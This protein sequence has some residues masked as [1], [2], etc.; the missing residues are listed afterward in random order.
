M[1]GGETLDV[2]LAKSNWLLCEEASVGREAAAREENG[3]AAQGDTPHTTNYSSD[4]T[5]RVLVVC[6]LCSKPA[7]GVQHVS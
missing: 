3:N 7:H 2:D 1:A 4:K 6:L 5:D